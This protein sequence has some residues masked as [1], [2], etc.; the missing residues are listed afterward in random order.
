MAEYDAILLVVAVALTVLLYW[1][2]WQ[3]DRDKPSEKPWT[4]HGIDVA[5][6]SNRVHRLRTD[7]VAELQSRSRGFCRRESLV[8]L[9]RRTV[10]RLPYFRNHPALKT[11][12]TE[13]E[14][15]NPAA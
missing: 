15:D 8:T 10:G 11:A 14:T 6:I 1:R 9:S 12:S 2:A 5:G 4:G 7:Y 13:Q 3:R